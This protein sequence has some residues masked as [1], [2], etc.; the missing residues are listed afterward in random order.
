MA[1]SSSSILTRAHSPSRARLHIQVRNR[2]AAGWAPGLGDR[3]PWLQVDLGT[4]MI[5]AGIG[6]QG[7]RYFWWWSMGGWVR[8]FKVS[9]QTGEKGWQIYGKNTSEEVGDVKLII[10][11]QK[12]HAKLLQL[13]KLSLILVYVR[14]FWFLGQ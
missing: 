1:F 13:D 11:L 12:K 10:V 4:R 6:T 9:F 3:T 14:D 7:G 8:K 2:Q 5:I